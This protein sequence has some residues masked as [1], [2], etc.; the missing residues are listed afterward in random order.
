ML[1]ME[2]HARS[3]PHV[4]L[5]V[6][7]MRDNI[8]CV[9]ARG[10]CGRSD[11]HDPVVENRSTTVSRTRQNCRT[12][13]HAIFPRL[14]ISC[15]DVRCSE[16]QSHSV[17]VRTRVSKQS[18]YREKISNRITTRLPQVSQVHHIIGVVKYGMECESKT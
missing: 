1:T 3:M 5:M 18:K 4:Q 15:H 9:R 17:I 14:P 2:P 13:Q 11:N 6:Y 16:P 10:G 7:H 12:G 8:C